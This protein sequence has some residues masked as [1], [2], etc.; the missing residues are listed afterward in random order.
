MRLLRS[1]R[2]CIARCTLLHARTHVLRFG[3]Y[4]QVIWQIITKYKSGWLAQVLFQVSEIAAFLGVPHPGSPFESS[5]NLFTAS[6]VSRTVSGTV[7][8]T[9]SPT[10]STTSSRTAA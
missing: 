8:S 10:R 5:R 3:Q 7:V 4:L 9:P 6:T 1:I 2:A